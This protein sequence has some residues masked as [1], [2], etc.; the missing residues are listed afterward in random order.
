MGLGLPPGTRIVLL[1][2]NDDYLVP[3][4]QTVLE[5]GDTLLGLAA[6]HDLAVVRGLLAAPV[7]S[8]PH[9]T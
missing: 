6:K 3:S 1:S 8:E 2:R 5:A 7:S 4:G 9:T